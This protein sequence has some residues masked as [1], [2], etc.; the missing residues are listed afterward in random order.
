MTRQYYALAKSQAQL[1]ELTDVRHCTGMDVYPEEY[2]AR[3]LAF[4]DAN[5]K[6]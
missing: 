2:A 3:M 6:P 1:W 5:L 4:F